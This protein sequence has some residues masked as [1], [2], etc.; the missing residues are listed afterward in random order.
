MFDEMNRRAVNYCL[1]RGDVGIVEERRDVDLLV[2]PSNRTAL[3]EILT[4]SG[5]VQRGRPTAPYKTVYVAYRGGWVACVDVHEEI[6]QD[7]LVYMDRDQ[8]LARRVVRD[9]VYVL[10]DEDLL[11]HLVWHNLL[12]RPASRPE[13]TRQ[14]LG[15]L[16]QDLDREYIRRHLDAFGLAGLFERACRFMTGD[17]GHPK[18]RSRL[19][20]EFRRAVCR[21][22]RGNWRTRLRFRFRRWQLGRRRGGLIALVGPDGSGKSTILAA[23]KR[24]AQALR[25]LKVETVYLGPWGQL[26]LPLIRRLRKAGIT[27]CTE[28]WGL[29]LAGRLGRAGTSPAS[30]PPSGCS[31]AFLFSKWVK[32]LGKGSLFYFAIYVEMLYR[33]FRWVFLQTRRGRW[34]VADRYVTDLRYLYKGDP[35]PNYRLLRFLVCRLFPKPDLFILLDN[36]P[37]VIHERKGDLSVEQIRAFRELYLKAIAQHRHEI[38]TTTQAPEEISDHVLRR[39]VQLSG[40]R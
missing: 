13:W 15:L 12:R 38:V 33:Y 34:V 21:H 5:F 11:L 19:Q 3:R 23:I 36:A 7:G 26:E 32:S 30:R 28:P 10:S 17:D 18:E 14:I 6:V 20:R 37:G 29:W 16:R 35:I 40:S 31:L 4:R 2:H 39:M 9:G 27:P 22:R 25:G 8:A 1:L 24:R